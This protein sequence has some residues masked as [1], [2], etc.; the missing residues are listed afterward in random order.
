MTDSFHFFQQTPITV[1]IFC[2]FIC[3][4]HINI[5]HT[6]DL[7]AAEQSS[8][9]YTASHKII[10]TVENVKQI[11]DC[12]NNV[13]TRIKKILYFV[14]DLKHKAATEYFIAILLK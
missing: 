2:T 8:Q 11:L 4:T 10:R 9:V 1:I 6:S 13:V 3:Y 14:S 7:H 12:A 5:F